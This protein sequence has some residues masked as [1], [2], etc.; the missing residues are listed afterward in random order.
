[1]RDPAARPQRAGE[2]AREL[3]AIWADADAS[4]DP[5][6]LTAALPEAATGGFLYRPGLLGRD[7]DLSSIMDMIETAASAP[8]A[9]LVAVSGR[10][11]QGKSALM[12]AVQSQ[13]AGRDQ[14]AITIAA[15]RGGRAPF[16]PFPAV[17]AAV[18]AVLD[19]PERQPPPGPDEPDRGGQ[20]AG[21]SAQTTRDSEDYTPPL[22]IKPDAAAVARRHLVSQLAETLRAA[23]QRRRTVLILDDLHHVG[24]GALAVL[25]ELLVALDQLEP[26]RPVVLI[27]TRPI[28]R[29]AID[30]AVA[31]ATRRSDAVA[32][33]DLPPLSPSA[34]RQIIA[35]MLAVAE[36]AVPQPVFDHLTE[37]CAGSPLLVQSA[38][39]ALVDRGH[40][41]LT[42]ADWR[43]A[44]DDLGAVIDSA[45]GDVLRTQ[46]AGVSAQTRSILAIAALCGPAFDIELL[47][48]VAERDARDLA[49]RDAGDVARCDEDTAL[50]AVDEA[51]RAS[52]LRRAPDRSAGE[53]YSFEH[54]QL[55][56]VLRGDLDK[57]RRRRIHDAIGAV[58]ADRGTASSATLAFHFSRGTDRTRAFRYLRRAGLAAFRAR[59][60][61]TARRHLD[62]A[63]GRIG[64]LAPA[65]QR[66]IRAQLLE[67]LADAALVTGDAHASI[68]YLRQLLAMT[69]AG[70]PAAPDGLRAA[71]ASSDRHPSAASSSSLLPAASSTS[72]LPAA[73]SSSLLPVAV[74]TSLLPARVGD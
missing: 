26:P 50:D 62:Q 3:A 73:S 68:D 71:T 44:C 63:L 33:I 8:G 24:S 7:R 55:A 58:L 39:R 32:F 17:L 28:G 41:R 30:A 6:R 43:V 47:V 67:F 70:A 36:S 61:H 64:D 15:H 49:E 69:G 59:D 25:G 40:L 1:M 4:A 20:A 38:V 16:A 13:L 45:V 65:R 21:A 72:L 27:A 34:V 42:G 22:L 14:R 74:D 31:A 11:G 52:L 9:R 5:A 29:A 66:G 35:A 2:V 56:E 23:H 37:V 57:G 60:Y 18:T 48:S 19:R 12:T 10:A 46:L 54:E 51:L 53:R